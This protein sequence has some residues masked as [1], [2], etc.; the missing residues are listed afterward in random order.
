MCVFG[1]GVMN[2]LKYWL[3]LSSISDI[4]PVNAKR[5]IEHFKSPELVWKA[6]EKQLKMVDG[7]RENI[8]R[9]IL[10]N[11]DEKFLNKELYKIKKY[12]VNAITLSDDTYPYNLKN[13]YSPPILF[14]AKGNI[15]PEDINAIAIVGSRNA[16]AYGLKVAY[17]LARQLSQIGITVVSGMARGVDTAAH[18]GAIDGGGRTIAVLGCGLD[19]IY[20]PENKNL[21]N[22]ITENGAVVSEYLLN[23]PPDAKHF[24]ARNRIISGLCLGV[25]VI[26]AN[27]R[28][29]SL[30]TADFA[31]EQNREVF[32]IPG[33]IFS[34][35]SQGTNNLI[36][37]GAKIV[38]KV[39]DI[40][41]ELNIEII[42]SLNINIEETNVHNNLSDE[43]NIIY[44]KISN[45]PIHLE[46]IMKYTGFTIGKINTIIT[47]LELKGLI[48]QL[49]GKQFVRI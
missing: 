26:E 27:I 6:S 31:L 41:E 48:T 23:T 13:I 32:A 29:G 42:E 49:P 17:D 9:A 12:N 10:S 4:G 18:K 15:K 44:S 16:T 7:I 30:I 45:L 25:V 33:Q 21:M 28:S 11:K 8:V 19:V 24:P 38:T 14:F 47:M 1:K 43:E 39:E 35:S 3:W 2:N 36:K 34:K 40:L 20:P 22:K 46:S 5:L 37:Q